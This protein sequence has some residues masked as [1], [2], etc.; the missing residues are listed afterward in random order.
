MANSPF[1]IITTPFEVWTAPVGTAFT[2]I[3][4]TPSASWTQLG[5]NR[6]AEGGVT[7]KAE[8]TTV[9]HRVEG[10]TGPVKITR[11]QESMSISF[12]LADL[13]SDALALYMTG[14]E[15]TTGTFVAMYRGL[16]IFERALQIK[17]ASPHA[18]SKNC[19]WQIPRATMTGNAEIQLSKSGMAMLAFVYTCI[20]DTNAVSASGRFGHFQ[21]AT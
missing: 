21:V 7:V 18:D 15:D 11:T 13:S 1:E 10:N 6:Q 5:S 16:T 20:E 14:A 8:Q 19:Q 17:G 2:A 9:E 3:A 4:S 12:A